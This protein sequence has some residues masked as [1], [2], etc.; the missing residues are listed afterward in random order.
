MSLFNSRA[1]EDETFICFLAPDLQAFLFPKRQKRK[2]EIKPCHFPKCGCHARLDTELRTYRDG[3][4]NI[5]LY[6]E[7]CLC[8]A[9][10]PVPRSLYS[11]ESLRELYK[12]EVVPR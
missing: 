9:S 7:T 12:R 4:K 10:S 11:R 1:A 6:C 3:T 2:Y 5:Y 8:R